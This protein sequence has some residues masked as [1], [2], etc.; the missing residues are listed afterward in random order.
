MSGLLC[1]T[2]SD[3]N[4]A[5]IF[6]NIRCNMTVSLLEM[7]N[8]LWANLWNLCVVPVQIEHFIIIINTIFVLFFT[9]IFLN[10]ILII[11]GLLECA[12]FS[13]HIWNASLL[14]SDSMFY[15]FILSNYSEMFFF[16]KKKPS[17]LNS[18]ALIHVIWTKIAVE[19]HVMYVTIFSEYI[20]YV[21][22]IL[23]FLW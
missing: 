8:K 13:T 1:L 12:S 10:V 14:Y 4:C 22:T 11:V 17:N 20:K 18:N 5:E 3:N 23:Y 21:Y 9:D 19:S 6:I 15:Q 16:L 7:F 2:D